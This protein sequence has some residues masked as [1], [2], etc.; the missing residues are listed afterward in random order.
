MA[1]TNA[2]IIFNVAI[3]VSG[4][5][6]AALGLVMY[7][8]SRKLVRGEVSRKNNMGIGFK[9]K[10]AYASDE[11]WYRIN[12]GGG[13]LM[14][15]PSLTLAALGVL[16]ALFGV[17]MAF[18]G[19]AFHFSLLV[20]IVVMVAIVLIVL[21]PSCGYWIWVRRNERKRKAA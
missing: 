10:E 2:E 7:Y 21:V 20:S 11:A 17:L 5:I 14:I 8:M 15:L 1:T 9:I 3:A 19:F 6:F 4:L 13:K 18:F 16:M 12:R